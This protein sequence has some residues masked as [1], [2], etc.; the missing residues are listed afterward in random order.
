MN[1]TGVLTF[2]VAPDFENASD[3]DGNNVFDVQVT[4]SDG[5]LQTMPARSVSSVEVLTG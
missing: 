2:I 3:A 5:S 1:T 4:V